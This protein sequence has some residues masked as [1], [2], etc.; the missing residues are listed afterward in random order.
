MRSPHSWCK[1]GSQGQFQLY[2]ISCIPAILRWFKSQSYKDKYDLFFNVSVP[3]FFQIFSFAFIVLDPLYPAQIIKYDMVVRL[4]Y[5]VY[6]RFCRF[7]DN[8]N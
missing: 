4:L 1:E 5:D 6:R 7:L 2:L 3:S 8:G